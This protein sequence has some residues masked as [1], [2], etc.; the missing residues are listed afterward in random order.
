MIDTRKKYNLLLISPKQDYVGYAAQAELAR[1]LGKKRLMTPLGLPLVAAYTPDYY[2]IRI[3]DEE[4]EKLPDNFLP[5]IVGI[6]TMAVSKTRS[7]QIGDM[8]RSKGIPVVMG[9][10]DASIIPGEYLKHANTVIVGEAENAWEH[11]LEDFE[12]GALKSTY[13]AAVKT[14]YLSPKKPRWDLVRAKDIFQVAVQITR[15]CPYNCEFCLVSKMYGKKMRFRDIDNVIEEIKT[16]PSKYIFFA[17]DNLTINKKYAHELVKRLKP[18][19]ISWGCMSSIEL[20]EDE[21]LLTGMAEAGCFNILIGFESL[22]PGSLDETHKD[23]AKGGEKYIDA[24]ARIHKAG[25]QIIGSFIVGFD[26]DTLDEFDRILDFTLRTGVSNI[27]LHLLAAPPG[28]DLHEKLKQ[29]GRI[30]PSPINDGLGSFPAIH[31]FNMGQVELYDKFMVTVKKLYTYEAILTRAKILFSSGAFIKPGGDI[32]FQTKI[33]LIGLVLKEFLF[34]RVPEKR[35]LFFFFLKLIG[36]RKIAKDKA[37]A[38]LL[39]MLSYHRQV[40]Y[41]MGDQEELRKLI[42]VND[43]GPWKDKVVK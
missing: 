22:N 21:E 7:F 37:F 6:S 25:I 4:T 42:R 20:A 17:D 9:G 26:H 31:Y 41:K 5:D 24:I 34:T 12:K 2:N 8:Y 27:N 29:Q 19:N 14:D 39:A 28:T 35:A 38:F 43:L 30:F 36:E 33:R 1:I 18:L 32:P 23:H 11:C 13:V 40:N 16:L 3:V 15:G 10:I